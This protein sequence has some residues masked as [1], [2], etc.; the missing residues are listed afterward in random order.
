MGKMPYKNQHNQNGKGG[1]IMKHR[2]KV[3]EAIEMGILDKD[4]VILCAL[5]YMSEDDV[6]E[7]AHINCFYDGY[8]TEEN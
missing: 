5:K 3:L 6:E 4:Y 8:E 7:L 1:E 2:N